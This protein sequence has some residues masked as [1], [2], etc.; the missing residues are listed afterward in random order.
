MMGRPRLS[1]KERF[2]ALQWSL[3]KQEF[4]SMVRQC[5]QGPPRSFVNLGCGSDPNFSEFQQ[6]GYTFVNFD[7]V[8]EMLYTLQ[9]EWGARACVAG[10]IASLPFR[11][12]SFDY[13]V[14]IDVLHHESDKVGA[15][16]E[17]FRELLK[18]GGLLFLRDP[19]AWGVFQMA[20]S[21]FLPRP[22][23]RGL[24]SAY[25]RIRH[26]THRPADYEFPTSV[27]RIRTTLERLGYRS[28]RVFANNAYP[29]ISEASFRLW[30]LFR[31]AEYVRKYCN[32]HY[33]LSASAPWA[34]D[35]PGAFGVESVPGRAT[36]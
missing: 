27:W 33:T 25:H 16:L 26:S 3:A 29:C 24:R 36:K 8:Y 19:N 28:I 13:V 11:R 6:Q 17:A 9:S 32:Y 21:V 30:R 34:D 15:L 23:Y 31:R 14:C 35:A 4:W 2:D 5:V 18:P 12:N 7:M 22:V 20:K 10:T 1:P